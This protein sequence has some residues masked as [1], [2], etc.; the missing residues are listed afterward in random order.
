ML[1]TMSFN[2]PINPTTADK[3]AYKSFL[4]QLQKILPCKYCRINLKNNMKSHPLLP[5][6][7][8]NRGAFSR[9][10]YKL[11]EVVNKMLKKKSGLTFCQVR[12]RYEN[13]RSRC[14]Q[15][16]LKKKIFTLTSIKNKTAKMR[17]RN[18]LKK[19]AGTKEHGCTEPL[20][21]EK[22]K[23]VIK[24]VPKKTPCD[25]FQMDGKCK[26]RRA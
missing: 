25:T 21:G 11:H 1:H 12:D 19:I 22:S 26:K 2:Y 5:C 15:D 3:N 9:Y 6:H 20:Y 10:V 18:K 23:C 17:Y 16:E 14:T 24:I 7:L 13:F 4:T 8:K